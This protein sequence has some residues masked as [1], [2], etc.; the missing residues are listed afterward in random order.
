MDKQ[1]VA[2]SHPER[3]V[4]PDINV[5]KQDVASYYARMAPWIMP[6]L[7]NRPVAVLRCPEGTVQDCFFQ[8]HHSAGLDVGTVGI[9][10]AQGG[11]RDYLVVRDTP[12]L[13]RLV[14][15]NA[16]EFHPWGAKADAPEL[17]DRLVFDLDPD[18]AVPWSAVKQAARH[19]HQRLGE[20]ALQSFLRTSGGK[21]LHVVVPLNPPAPWEEAKGFARAFADSLAAG[22]PDRYLATAS[23][24]KR[25]GLI[26]IDYLRNTRG[27][28][29]ICSYS[30]RARPGAPVATPLH[31]EALGRLTS[32]AMYDIKS[33][34]RRLA[35]LKA[36]PWEAIAEIRQQLPRE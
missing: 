12:D 33:L 17:C 26:F 32:A 10:E 34:P 18:A 7:A 5:T 36:D 30:L 13:M 3:L 14:Q 22:Y 20:L 28:T 31:W 25:K 24:Q 2:I 35:R 9:D 16:I 15:M 1:R 27:A 8:K 4:Y 11:A 21:G 23:K 29:S 6:A 19:L